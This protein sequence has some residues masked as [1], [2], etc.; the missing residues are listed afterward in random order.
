MHPTM[1]TS[2]SWRNPAAK[3]TNDITSV[4]IDINNQ[5]C[6]NVKK[7]RDLTCKIR[8]AHAPPKEN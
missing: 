6:E 2:A 4:R 5:D 8:E 3:E 1:P 7:G